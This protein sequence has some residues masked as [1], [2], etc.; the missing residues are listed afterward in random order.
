MEVVSAEVSLSSD[1]KALSHQKT[2]EMPP[3]ILKFS[4][5][6]NATKTAKKLSPT[7]GFGGDEDD[8]AEEN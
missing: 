6:S 8:A 2:S 3:S 5:S 1:A 4:A 7:K